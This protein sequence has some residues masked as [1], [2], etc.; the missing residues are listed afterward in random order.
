MAATPVRL[1]ADMFDQL[2][3]GHDATT[4]PARARLIGVDRATL[5]RMRKGQLV[6]SVSLAMHIARVLGVR[7]EDLF[8][9][10]QAAGAVSA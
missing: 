6:P 5:W 2:T 7:V 1:R 10:A 4:D 3:A 8:E 9:V